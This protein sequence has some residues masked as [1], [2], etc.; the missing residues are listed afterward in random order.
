LGVFVAVNQAEDFESE[1]M[2]RETFGGVL[3]VLLHEGLDVG[4]GYEGEEFEVSLYVCICGA[5]EE[6]GLGQC[7]LV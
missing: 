4:K 2:L 6:L 5:K 7:W 3:S 1:A